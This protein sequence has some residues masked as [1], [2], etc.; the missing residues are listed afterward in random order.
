MYVK[1]KTYNGA[2]KTLPH[3]LW[4]VAVGPNTI[5]SPEIPIQ[6]LIVEHLISELGAYLCEHE[7]L[8]VLTLRTKR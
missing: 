8:H 5:S 7:Q 4:V 6:I 1:L 3:F 2:M